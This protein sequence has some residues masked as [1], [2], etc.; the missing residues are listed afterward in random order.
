MSVRGGEEEERHLDKLHHQLAVESGHL[1]LHAQ[2][3][4]SD[5]EGD[6]LIVG[7]AVTHAVEDIQV[8]H[9]H[10]AV[11]THVKHLEER[12]ERVRPGQ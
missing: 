7:G 10:V 9:H 11:Q 4:A 3:P 12:R 6:D 1:S 2:L 5:G 8:L